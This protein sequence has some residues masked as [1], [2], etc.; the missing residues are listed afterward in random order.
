MIGIDPH[1]A[2]H[3][4]AAIDE[5]ESGARRAACSLR[6]RPAGAALGMGGDGG[7]SGPGRSRAQAVSAICSP[8][9]SSLPASGS[10]TSS[11]SSRPEC[12]CSPP[13]DNKNDPNDARSVAIAALRSPAVKRGPGR[14]PRGGDEGVGQAPSR[15]RQHRTQSSAG[16]TRAL[17]ARPRWHSPG[18]IYAAKAANMLDEFE[19]DDC[20]GHRPP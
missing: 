6:R 13:L 17:R 5:A 4:A 8:S 9:S 18:M 14:G 20:G 1:K 11:R 2:S 3:T 12:G 7:R 16:C 15:P 10:S 19:P